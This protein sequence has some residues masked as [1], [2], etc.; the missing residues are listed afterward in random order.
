MMV[1]ELRALL[2]DIED[3]GMSIGIAKLRQGVSFGG[4]V[5]DVGGCCFMMSREEW[6]SG[7]RP[8]IALVRFNRDGQFCHL[9]AKNGEI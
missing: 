9:V 7:G 2:F 5:A 3:Q 6:D 1:R 4:A 8:P